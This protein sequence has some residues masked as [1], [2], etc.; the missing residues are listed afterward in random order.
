MAALGNRGGYFIYTFKKYFMNLKSITNLIN[1]FVFLTSA[2]LFIVSL[3]QPA[4][5]TESDTNEHCT[6]S[7]TA[8]L[9]GWLGLLAGSGGAL[10][11]VANLF[12]FLTWILAFNTPRY[13][14]YTSIFT[15]LLMLYFLN[16][17]QIIINEAGC[18]SKI[19]SY[20]IG[21]W[22]WIASA[23][24]LLIGNGFLFLLKKKTNYN[25]EAV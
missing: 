13:T 20:G 14:I 10:A 11:W 25:I 6:Q 7:L 16:I 18:Y 23:V 24:T 1:W 22:L 3:T 4:Y 17:D 9:I 2:M 8:F 21:Y 15:L 12:L 5:C 19:T